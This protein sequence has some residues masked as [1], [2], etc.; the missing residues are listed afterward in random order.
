MLKSLFAATALTTLALAPAALAQTP[1]AAT[2][3]MEEF[4]DGFPDW[5]P[6]FAVV[7][8]TADEVLFTHVSGDRRADTGLPLTVDTPLY[9]AS[10]TKPQLGLL[11]ARLHHEGILDL[12]SSL[13]S[14][15][16]DF[17]LPEGVDPAQYT[18]RDLLGHT[19]PIESDLVETLDAYVTDMPPEDFKRLVEQHAT[20]REPGYVYDNLNYNLYA[21]ILET[22]TG[23]DWRSWLEDAVFEPLGLSGT[24]ARSSDYP[25]EALAWNHL[26]LGEADGWHPYPPKSDLQ[27]HSAGGSFTTV[28][29]MAAWLQFQLRQSGPEGS[30]L[31]AE[32]FQTTLTPVVQTDPE[33][34]S[35]LELP[36][37]AYTLGWSQCDFEGRTVY[38]RGGDYTGM[39]TMHAFSPD[40]GVGI[41]V[42]SVSDNF[43]FWTNSRT[44]IQFFQYL[45]DDADA[46]RHAALR[47]RVYPQ[48]IAQYLERR[49]AG[50]A[51][52]RQ[53]PVWQGWAWTPEPAALSAYTGT[54]VSAEAYAPVV[55][56]L[57]GEGLSAAWGA[58]D[59]GLDPA[60]AD[61]FGAQTH[62][63]DRPDP[64]RFE[65]D[66]QGHVVALTFQG[67]RFERR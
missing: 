19:L 24:A 27:L 6:G 31:T 17:Q 51:Q 32:M 33:A 12:D 46:D 14:H 49:Q 42:F 58:L 20:A 7:A 37:S 52:T 29:D 15:W 4:L 3:R 35:A 40:L 1:E 41:G 55:I 45:I 66:D 47:Q 39:S 2:E 36:C 9:I 25:P 5:G 48:R 53:E 54:Y 30:G 61:L 34:R 38:S 57:E 8:V 16:P 44:V 10:Q 63:L 43:T 65:R 28:T 13:A 11:A 59:H 18:L 60:A 62:P 50:V 67:F 22:A 21:A 26:W 64:V 56:S 23:R